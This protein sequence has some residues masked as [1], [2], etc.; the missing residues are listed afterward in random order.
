MAADERNERQLSE[1]QEVE[2]REPPVPHGD[3]ER[4]RYGRRRP[5]D[6]AGPSHNKNVAGADRA[7][8][9][10]DRLEGEDPFE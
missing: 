5:I 1:A 6:A 9:P 2:H 7:G 10:L 8:E 4:S 3:N